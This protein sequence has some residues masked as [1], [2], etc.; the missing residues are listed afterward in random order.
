MALYDP[1]EIEAALS[2]VGFVEDSNLNGMHLAEIG[3]EADNVLDL[4]ICLRVEGRN[5][6]A[7]GGSS[8]LIEL[9][10]ALEHLLH[11]AQEVLPSL[12]KQLDFEPEEVFETTNMQE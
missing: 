1:H 10:L 11:H 5:N 4:L 2:A 3:E 12:Q 7:E 8:T 6:D 9:T